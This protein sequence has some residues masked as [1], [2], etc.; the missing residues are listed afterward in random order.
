MKKYLDIFLISFL[1][2][3]AFQYFTAKEQQTANQ[4]TVTSGVQISTESKSYDV[5][6]G[7]FLD[8]KNENAQ[9]LSFNSCSDLQVFFNGTPKKIPDEFCSDIDLPAGETAKIDYT[10]IYKDFSE[11]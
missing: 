11:P 4:T 6:A 1:L 2:L 8:I 10:K 5:P 3:F 9:V 7:I